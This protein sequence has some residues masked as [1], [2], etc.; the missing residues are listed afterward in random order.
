MLKIE[1]LYK[2]YDNAN[3]ES[4]PILKDINLVVPKKSIAAV[5]G[6]S[7]SGKST[8]SKCVNLLERPSSGSI[9]ID[10]LDLKRWS[11]LFEQ[12]KAYL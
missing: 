5:L 9:K 2:S 6:P 4:I 12:L 3:S 8:L 1:H 11:H 10:D 7:G